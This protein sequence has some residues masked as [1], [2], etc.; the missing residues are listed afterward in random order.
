ML[1]E[2]FEDIVEQYQT[3]V[4]ALIDRM[5]NSMETARDLAQ[6]SFIRL[7]HYRDKIKPDKP[8]FTLIYKIA[9]NISIDYL[10]KKKTDTVDFDLTTSSIERDI[11][12]S[13]EVFRIVL[14]CCEKL[15]PKQKAVFVLRD[16]EG[17]SFEEIKYIMDMPIS[18]IRS[19][20]HLARK[21][22]RKMMELEYQINQE[23]IYEL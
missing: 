13:K 16:I 22:V 1:D 10:R 15:K 20:L 9:M 2:Q 12:D 6:D 11:L 5:V 7:W 18:N 17:Y 8:L 3:S 19:N 4:I 14:S 23:L 21:N